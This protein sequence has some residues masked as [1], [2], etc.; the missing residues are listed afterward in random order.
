MSESEQDQELNTDQK[1][2]HPKLVTV[3]VDDTELA[4]LDGKLNLVKYCANL[5]HNKS[6][7][8]AH[9]LTK[10]H[11]N[12]RDRY[13]GN[14]WVILDPI[15]Q[16]AVYVLIFGV[17]L[18]IDRGMDNFIGFL[19]IGVVFFGVFST[20]ITGGSN[21][22]QNSRSLIT[23]FKF[24]RIAIVVSGIVKLFLDKLVPCLL[25][26]VVA[27]A[28]QWG[29]PL[30]WGII[31]VVPLYFLAH[32]FAFGTTAIVARITAFI[33]DAKSVISLLTRGLFFLSGIFFDI[34]RFDASP[35]LKHI[36]ELNPIYQ[37]LKAFRSC[38]IDGTIPDAHTWIFLTIWSL[39]L[40][41]LGFIFFYQA[42]ERYSVV[43]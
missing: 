9:A 42:E 15:F 29:E 18:K 34:S 21:L 11:K 10:V 1:R 32:L 31:F 3:L 22:I 13:L 14:L 19:V 43:K 23:S 33:P 38:T 36:V 35:S 30:H 20:G 24:P 7:I 26:I 12:G 6:F 28:F 25:A 39:T 17:I 2:D 40:A 8:K 16:V 27:V 5:W 4:P 37:F 41:I